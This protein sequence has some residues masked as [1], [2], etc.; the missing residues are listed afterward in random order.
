MNGE[1]DTSIATAEFIRNLYN[2]GQFEVL[3]QK[4]A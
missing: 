4:A 3:L 2:A 1:V